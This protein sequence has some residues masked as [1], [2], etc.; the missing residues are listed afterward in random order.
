M[1]VVVVWC[2]H[3][4]FQCCVASINI[5][6]ERGKSTRSCI[7][8][9]R[10]NSCTFSSSSVLLER[11]STALSGRVGSFYFSLLRE[12]GEKCLRWENIGSS[13]KSINENVEAKEEEKKIKFIVCTSCIA[14]DSTFLT[15]CD[16]ELK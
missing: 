6:L 12:V 13:N 16:D 7:F 14:L 2:A 11:S 5:A 4:C 15:R 1:N 10:E 3:E 8:Y 9:A